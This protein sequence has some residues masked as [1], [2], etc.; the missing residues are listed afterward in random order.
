MIGHLS[1]AAALAATAVVVSACVETAETEGVAPG[2]TAP[3]SMVSR[4]IER[5][6][7]FSVKE[8][9]LWDGRPSLGGV[10]VAHPDVTD[11][12]RVRITNTT[13]GQSVAGALFRRERA[14]PGPRIQLSSDAAAE[15]GVLAGQPTELEVVVV[16]VEEIEVAPP[17]PV[18][19]AAGDGAPVTDAAAAVAG[20]AVAAVPAAASAGDDVIR[21][22]PWPRR[23]GG[24][25]SGFRRPAA[26][27]ASASDLATEAETAALAPPEVETTP[28]DTDSIAAAIDEAEAREAS[29]APP[30]G[31]M[32]QVGLFSTEGNAS[33]AAASLRQAGIVPTVRPVTVSGKRRWSVLVG[34]VTDADEQR[35]LI[36][37]I[38]RLGYDD[39]YLT[40][41]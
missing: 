13:N 31:P 12:E 19:P 11:P 37:T 1:R 10:W 25:F 9:A 8:P 2:L 7:I 23:G 38:R 27:A 39:A 34:P 21:P 18:A 5:P 30:S 3:P 14:N 41:G 29:P 33:S 17:E 20:S 4:D 15:L 22:A 36:S 40:S 6:D 24:L 32:I 28:L 16:R 35:D 26:A